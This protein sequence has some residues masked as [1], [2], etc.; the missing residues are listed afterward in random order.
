M[1]T[2]EAMRHKR[3]HTP[4][5]LVWVKHRPSSRGTGKVAYYA[6]V[7]AAATIEIDR[8]ITAADIEIEIVYS[9]TRKIA[10][11]LDADNVNKP[12]LDA[13]KGIAYADDVQVRSVTSTLF[14]RNADHIAHGRVEHM[15]RLFYSPHPDVVLLLPDR[16]ILVEGVEVKGNGDIVGFVEEEVA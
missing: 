14:D 1:G 6:A 7:K 12:T 2:I 5:Y 10:G 15:G 8:P 9:T 13:L 11:R 3:A 4:T 16:F